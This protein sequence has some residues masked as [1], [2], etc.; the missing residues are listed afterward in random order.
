M[1]N[2][3]DGSA[4]N[5]EVEMISRTNSSQAARH[6]L[7]IL[8]GLSLGTAAMLSHAQ[9]TCT[10]VGD[11]RL[12]QGPEGWSSMTTIGDITFVTRS[13]G[14]SATMQRIG[15]VTIITD[16]REG[17]S[18]IVHHVGDRTIIDLPDGSSVCD[19]IDA[20]TVCS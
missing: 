10:S 20:T 5:I 1:L 11:T 15:D 16:S 17:M 13:D 12:C 8:L 3:D 9:S 2:G 4:K 7:G 14:S 19:K 6:L 18:G